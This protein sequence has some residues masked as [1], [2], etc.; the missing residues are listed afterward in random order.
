MAQKEGQ[1]KRVSTYGGKLTENA[2]QAVSREILAPAMH[3]CEDAGYNII[4]TVY[5]EIVC[6]VPE[7]FGSKEEFV[8]LMTG[9]LPEWARGWPIS[10]DAWE[11]HRYKK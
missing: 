8:S 2:C 1:W 7:D 11:G 3:R 10:V 6:E 4:L 5:D 9:P